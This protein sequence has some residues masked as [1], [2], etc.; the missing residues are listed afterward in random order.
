MARAS[1]RTGL[2]IRVGEIKDRCETLM[3]KIQ[4]LHN[5]QG[6]GSEDRLAKANLV[7]SFRSRDMAELSTRWEFS[8]DNDHQEK[9]LPR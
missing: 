2:L 3:D 1:K 5:E 6:N 4:S 9:H 7:R 8:E